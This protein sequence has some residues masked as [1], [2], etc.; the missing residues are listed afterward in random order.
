MR[1][2]RHRSPLDGDRYHATFCQTCGEYVVWIAASA[3][4]MGHWRAVGRATG[5]SSRSVSPRTARLDNTEAGWTESE[6]REAYGR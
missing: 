6:L 4:R 1:T 3:D 5:R 2:H